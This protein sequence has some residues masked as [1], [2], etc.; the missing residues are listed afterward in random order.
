MHID[1][2]DFIATIYA[3]YCFA[4]MKQTLAH[5]EHQLDWNPKYVVFNVVRGNGI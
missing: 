3:R 1:D 4:L 2:I 5:Y